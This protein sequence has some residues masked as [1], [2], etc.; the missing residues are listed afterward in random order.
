MN[1]VR[2]QDTATWTAAESGSRVAH[3]SLLMRVPSSLP[4]LFAALTFPS[5]SS[6]SRFHT[7]GDGKLKGYSG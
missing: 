5:S 6:A 7:G 2:F 4:L 1:S 3:L